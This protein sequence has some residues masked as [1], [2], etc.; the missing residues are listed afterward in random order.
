MEVGDNVNE[1]R[2]LINRGADV[3]YVHRFVQEGMEMSITALGNAAF[4]GH[5]NVVTVLIEKGANVNKKEP[6]YGFTALHVAAQSGRREAALRLLDHGA[7]VNAKDNDG[8]TPLIYAAQDGHLS[9]VDLL[10]L[11]GADPNQANIKGATPR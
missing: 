4:G 8:S 5:A 10:I 7:D 6:C 1:A 11:R 3:N 9:L 2:R